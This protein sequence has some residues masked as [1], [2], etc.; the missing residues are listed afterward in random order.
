VR[1]EDHWTRIEDMAMVLE[2]CWSPLRNPAGVPFVDCD[3][4]ADPSRWVE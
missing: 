3:L 2:Y 1:D 4:V